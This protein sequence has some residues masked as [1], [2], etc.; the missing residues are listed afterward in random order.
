MLNHIVL[1]GRLV[2]D[3]TAR[4]TNS[5]KQVSSF[6]IAVD[7]DRK[8]P[9]G[10]RETDFVDCVAWGKTA[11]HVV[12]FFKKGSV[13]VVSGRLQMRE[14]TDKERNKRTSAEVILDS[15]YFGD[16]KRDSGPAKA[17]PVAFQAVEDDDGELPF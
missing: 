12:Q 8:G 16:S 1:M 11:E 3:P 13:A 15:I 6:R 9:D 4:F 7:R 17:A 10:S 2:S 14:W 5:G